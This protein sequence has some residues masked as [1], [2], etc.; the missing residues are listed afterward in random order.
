ML[1]RLTNVLSVVYGHI[2]FPS[3]TNG[4]KDVA[5]CLGYSWTDEAASG[6]QSIVWRKR[7]DGMH[8][9]AWKQRLVTYNWR[10]A[11]P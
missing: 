9:E 7:W 6:I 5:A 10:I 11:T 3:Y 1:E 4:L 8:D 2:Y